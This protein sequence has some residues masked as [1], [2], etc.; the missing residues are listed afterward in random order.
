MTSARTLV[1]ASTSRYRR[2]LL[3]RLG[4]VHEAVAHRCDEDAY[5]DG[6]LA[7]DELART[8]ARAKAESVRSMHLDSFVIGSDQLLNLDG[9][10]LG[11][12]GTKERANAQLAMLSGRTHRLVTALAVITP[13]GSLHEH[14]EVHHMRMRTLRA[15]EIERYVDVDE[16]LDCAGSY[17]IERLGIALFERIDG[18]DFTAIEGMPLL[19]LS[20]LL[21]REGFLLPRSAWAL[22]EERGDAPHEALAERGLACEVLTDLELERRLVG[23]GVSLGRVDETTATGPRLVQRDAKSVGVEVR[24]HALGERVLPV[25]ENAD[26]HVTRR[27]FVERREG[28]DRRRTVARD[29]PN[30]RSIASWNGR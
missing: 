25:E 14:L 27:P 16:P 28:V 12:P 24:V 3:E 26:L 21:R 17:R 10:V 18:H 1:L 2:A 13:D 4:L 6:S 20:N 22:R 15:E 23:V 7:P 29:T 5:K 9:A 30:E 11:K 8:L 19:A